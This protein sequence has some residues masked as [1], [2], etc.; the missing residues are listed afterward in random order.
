L[1]NPATNR[2][3]E[4]YASATSVN[5]GQQINFY[6]NTASSSYT[7]D[8]YRMGWYAGLGGRQ[9][10]SSVTVAGTQQSIPA[11][12][13]TT[14]LVACNWI[15]PYTLTTSVNWTSGYYLA[16]LTAT[17]SG[18]QSYIIFIVR[19]DS[20]KSNYLLQ[21]AVTTYQA[22]NNWGGKSLY[23]FNCVDHIA[24]VKVS[25]NRPYALGSNSASGPG[26]GAGEFITNFAPSYET[27][28]AGWEYNMVRFLESAGY[29]VTY[30]TDVDTHANGATLLRNHKGFLSVGHDEYWSWEM[31]T[32]AEAARDAGVSLGFFGADPCYWEI[33]FE[34]DANS[35]PN[36]TIVAYKSTADTQDPYAID[37]D[38]SNDY[39]ITRLWRQNTVK[40]P[41][42]AMIGVM[43]I[44]DPVNANLVIEDASSWVCANTGLKDGDSLLG[45]LGYEVDCMFFDAPAGT[46]RVGHSVYTYSDGTS[47]YP[48]LIVYTAGSGATVFATG[49]MQW[50]WG[51]DNYN[52]PGLRPAYS[53]SAA[54]QMTR[55]VLASFVG[56][57]PAGT[58][59]T[60]TVPF[61]DDFNDNSMDA[62]KWSL[63]AIEATLGVGSGAWDPNVTVVE[64]NQELE[65]TPLTRMTGSH[66]NGYVSLATLDLTNASASV[67]VIQ[68]A[69]GN[70]D[71][72]LALC[73]D[74]QNHYKI[75][76]E[77]SLLYFTQVLAGVTT[78]S[79]TSYS[80]VDHRFWR[81]R[82]I[83]STDSLVFE[84]SADGQVWSMRD[85]LVRKISVKALKLE[86]GAG[87]NQSE[88]TPGTAI[89][90]NVRVEAR[91]TSAT[92]P[93]PTPAPSPTPS[94]TVTPETVSAPTKPTGP[95]T[96]YTGTAY[97]FSTSGSVDNLGRSVQYLFN[98]GD[99]TTSGW[100]PVGTKSATKSWTYKGAYTVTAQARSAVNTSV[101]SA[102]STGLAVNILPETVSTP[103]QPT[104]TTSGYTGT[105]YTYYTGGSVD[106]LG[107]SVQ[108]LFNWGDGTT[109]GW[110]PVG[111]KS[112]TKSWT[113]K[114]AYAVKALARSAT[115]T[116]VV[117]AY[118]TGLTVT[119]ALKET[120]STPKQPTGPTSGY[121][122]G[123]YTY[124]TGGSVDNLGYSVQYLFNW[125]DGTTS[126]W[127]PVGTTS[128]RKSWSA[129][130]GYT[131]RAQARS[132]AHTTVISAYSTGLWV[133]ML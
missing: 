9:V 12:N 16:K 92:A 85:S 38:T 132:A 122:G 33:R 97:T 78:E 29:D 28:C 90:D 22:Y 93:A 98:W 57:R 4:G 60:I 110:L 96:G 21:S 71:T 77:G 66:Y 31:R 94:A 88:R 8:V 117:S 34:A 121:T 120:V 32:N 68:A 11:P 10:V 45:L 82:H 63:G 65:I 52:S 42:D 124:Y 87:T 1:S 20:S 118:S 73:I 14:G 83:Y 95:T 108:Y 61:A 80:P 126:G 107:Y 13:S 62:N 86:I 69:T 6:V 105:S 2:E 128:A 39:L 125:G 109:S 7:I 72:Y 41:E 130:A 81:I 24:A 101:V 48:D 67:E 127:L 99:G 102:Y 15:K 26:M 106:N 76:K 51:L 35:V 19:D 111:T 46:A 75:E 25:F 64:Q 116:T 84:T 58:T 47:V 18:K 89:F 37:S 23:A 44:T 74:G 43:Y 56:A 3:I 17:N 113:Y 50:N 54:Q 129:H 59:P 123:V 91:A 119:I 131:V 30:C 112:A 70:A 103:N 27:S 114:G 49:S 53:S 133:N 115:H 36:R 55:N 40:P 100:L 104:G 5:R 79:Y